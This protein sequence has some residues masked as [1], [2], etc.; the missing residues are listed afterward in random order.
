[1]QQKDSEWL[2]PIDGYEILVVKRV[3]NSHK[4]VKS[5]DLRMDKTGGAHIKNP[6]DLVRQIEDAVFLDTMGTR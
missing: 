2:A 1:M 4:Q 3:P 6:E 5:I